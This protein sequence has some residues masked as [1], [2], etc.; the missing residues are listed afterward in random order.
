MDGSLPI[1]ECEFFETLEA[2][3]SAAAGLIFNTF[4]SLVTARRERSALLA[5]KPVRCED[6]L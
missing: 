1:P 3:K 5:E 2:A 6:W 4:Q